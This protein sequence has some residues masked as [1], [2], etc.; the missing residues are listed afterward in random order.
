MYKSAIPTSPLACYSYSLTLSVNMPST[1]VSTSRSVAAL[2]APSS[3][4]RKM[5]SRGG[6]AGGAKR[7]ASYHAYRVQRDVAEDEDA[8]FG[9][10]TK[11]LGFGRFNFMIPDPSDAR[12][13]KQRRTLEVQ[14]EAR[15]L[16]KKS[17]YNRADPLRVGEYAVI[18]TSGSEYE[19][20][21]KLPRELAREYLDEG[22]IHP[23]LSSEL[24][25]TT[26]CGIEF[27]YEASAQA[28]DAEI[29][30]RKS[31]KNKALARGLESEV[32]VPAVPVKGSTITITVESS[33][34]VDINID[35]I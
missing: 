22:R 12:P 34:D 15:G 27:D 21:L 8:L 5:K 24:T 25:A 1:T 32:I 6:K 28:V 4:P 30:A 17:V 9:V 23:S 35:D 29:A 13:I 16:A 7:G 19:I 31:H 10:V 11:V 18:A 26:D 2:A 33:T 14:A 20:L 3:V